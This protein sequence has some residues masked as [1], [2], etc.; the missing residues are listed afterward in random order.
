MTRS[1]WKYL[2]VGAILTRALAL[3]DSKVDAHLWGRAWAAGGLVSAVLRLG[4]RHRAGWYPGWTPP[5]RVVSYRPWH[6]CSTLWRLV[7]DLR[8]RHLRHA[9]PADARAWRAVHVPPAPAAHISSAAAMPAAGEPTPAPAKPNPRRSEPGRG[10]AKPGTADSP[11]PS[12]SDVPARPTGSE[13]SDRHRGIF[14]QW[15]ID[16]QVPAGAKV[17]INGYENPQ[18]RD[19]PAVHVIRPSSREGL[20]IRRNG[21]TPRASTLGDPRPRPGIPGSRRS[22][23]MPAT[24]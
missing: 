3:G 18:P 12:K 5:I 13:A 7:P 11:G 1:T 4:S 6:W 19:P 23:S 9:T 15:A 20:S 16:I 8:V 14:Q 10:D 21:M 22:T 2:L 24:G 17:F